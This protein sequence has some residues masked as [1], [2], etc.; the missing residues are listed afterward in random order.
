LV[1]DR[2]ATS[3]DLVERVA[4]AVQGG[5][6]LVQLREKDLSGGQ[7]LRLA[8]SLLKAIGGSASLIVNERADVA[9]AAGAQGVQLGEDGL[10]VSAA[11]MTVGSGALVGRS[12]H[13]VQAATQAEAE[14]A[15]FLVV[16]TM[17]ASRSHPGEAPAGPG[18]M[19]Q[20]SEKCRLPLI[21]IGGITPENAPEVIEAG[22][23]GV[24]VISN[25]LAAPDP[26]A[27]AEKL[28]EAIC[29]AWRVFGKPAGASPV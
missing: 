3:G 8:E 20:I 16:G 22:A 9:V 4:L 13:S 7:L 14:G 24:A 18:L 5:V 23:S 12:V 29:E 27:A 21:G 2:S 15:D 11:R 25:I 6:D 17:F 28:K 1:T 10:P 26:K 19:R